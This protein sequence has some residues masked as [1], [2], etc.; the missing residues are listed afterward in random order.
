MHR[1]P[2]G[3]LY[4]PVGN[5]NIQG[6]FAGF[7]GPSH[8]G[9]GWT[10][11]YTGSVGLDSNNINTN[12]DLIHGGSFD[13]HFVR[14]GMQSCDG[15]Y[16]HVVGLDS[17]GTEFQSMSM[18]NGVFNAS[19]NTVDWTQVAIPHDLLNDTTDGSDVFNIVN[20][21]WS[22][23]G[24][25]GYAYII[26]V[27][28]L[29]PNMATQPITYK[30]TDHGLTW[31]QMAAFDFT[32]LPEIMTNLNNW[33]GGVLGYTGTPRIN[34]CSW[35]SGHDA[36]VD[37][38]GDLHMYVLVQCGFGT[39]YSQDSLGYIYTNEP[40]ILYDIYTTSSGWSARVIDTILTSYVK[41]EDSG[42]GS[43]ADAMG[44]DHR[45]QASRSYDGTKLFCTWTDTDTT[46]ALNNM[47][48][49]IKVYGYDILSGYKTGV[50]NF[51]KG[52]LYDGFNYFHYT[53]NL[54]LKQGTTYTIPMTTIQTG[55]DPSSPIIHEYTSGITF[56]EADFVP[57]PGIDEQDNFGANIKL[58]PNPVEDICNIEID[59][60]EASNL[61]LSVFNSAGQV[62]SQKSFGMMKSGNQL[63]TIDLKS[64]NTGFYM[65]RLQAGTSAVNLK[66]IV[67]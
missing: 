65:I 57:N 13:Q 10:H 32:T 27:D 22:Q 20:T 41:A 63:L 46:M 1:Y 15:G 9:T 67:K 18:N 43:G 36:V 19:T 44:W 49:D 25:V 11:W 38:N 61:T 16:F 60:K 2:S 62:V 58:Y 33:W 47:F 8:L 7:A 66:T 54:T 50:V 14:Y 30:S 42:F 45:I 29:D 17:I 31:S 53:S 26:G 28:S 51:T 4:N 6:A 34:F 37:A 39:T 24:S 48:P 55:A 64:L 40:K 59:L 56:E 3:A 35:F 23:D 5:T 12:Y 21:A 52:T